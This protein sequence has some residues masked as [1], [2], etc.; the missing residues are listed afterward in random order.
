M[1]VRY[2]Q[3]DIRSVK[4][5]F[6]YLL[7]RYLEEKNI[8]DDLKTSVLSYARQSHI[9]MGKKNGYSS[10]ITEFITKKKVKVQ[11]ALPNLEETDKFE[12]IQSKTG[13][14]TVN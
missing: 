12:Y 3:A 9:A 10:L 5:G 6:I 4:D 7:A 1:V 13:P 14:A 2:N 11:K 8:P